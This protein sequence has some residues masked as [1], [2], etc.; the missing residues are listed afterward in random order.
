MGENIQFLTLLTH[1]LYSK[2]NKKVVG[3]MKDDTIKKR[4]EYYQI[5]F[6]AGMN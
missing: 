1:F 4:N 3:K 6:I 2:T 5:M